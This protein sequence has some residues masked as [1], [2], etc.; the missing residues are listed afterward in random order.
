MHAA[1]VKASHR[2]L[3]RMIFGS[4]RL[5]TG[6]V[7][8]RDFHLVEEAD[9]RATFLLHN[10]V[11]QFAVEAAVQV[12]EGFFNHVE[13]LHFSFLVGSIIYLEVSGRLKKTGDRHEEGII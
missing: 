10:V 9:G 12:A 2:L 3:I 4:C 7:E 8:A 11:D 13:V 5:A 6:V 1:I